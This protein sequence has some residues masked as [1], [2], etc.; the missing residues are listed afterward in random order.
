MEPAPWNFQ[1]WGIP[2]TSPPADLVHQT[3]ALSFYERVLL[4]PRYAPGLHYHD[5]FIY[6]IYRSMLSQSCCQRGLQTL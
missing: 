6:I 4:S 3:I 2:H 5:K 1:V